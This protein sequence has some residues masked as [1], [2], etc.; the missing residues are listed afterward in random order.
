MKQW[1]EIGGKSVNTANI[2][3]IQFNPESKNL[4]LWYSGEGG[5][6]YIKCKNNRITGRLYPMIMWAIQAQEEAVISVMV[7]IK[8]IEEEIKKT[9]AL[10]TTELEAENYEVV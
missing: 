10:Q 6:E 7:M 9:D 2:R 8:G 4:A 5:V 1:L 3:L